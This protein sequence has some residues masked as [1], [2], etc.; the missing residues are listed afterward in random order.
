MSRRRPIDL[1]D[2]QRVLELADEGL[3]AQQI[4]QRLGIS[5]ETTQHTLI[6]GLTDC[7]RCGRIIRRGDQCPVCKLSS[8][9]EFGARLKAFRTAADLSQL[10]LSLQVGVTNAR[11]R[12]WE[13]GERQPAEHELEMLA[14]VLGLS[15]QEL[16]GNA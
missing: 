4:A 12:H 3:S 8:K 16:T 2:R 1:R 15:V 5:V 9:A 14:E 7:G 10:Q 13:N 11:V 6:R